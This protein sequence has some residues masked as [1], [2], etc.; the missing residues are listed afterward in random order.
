MRKCD[1]DSLDGTFTLTDTEIDTE[2]V[3]MDGNGTVPIYGFRT[4]A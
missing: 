3:T 2:N 1:V 4:H